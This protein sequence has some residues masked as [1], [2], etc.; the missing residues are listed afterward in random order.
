MQETWVGSLVGNIPWSRAWQPAPIFLPGESYE[1][2]SLTGYSQRGQKES[3][4]TE[5]TWHTRCTLFLLDLTVVQSLS[6]APLF[7]T[8]WT[9]AC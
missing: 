9:T 3:D 4:A 2:R 5:A 7:A 6:C 8:P 1:Q